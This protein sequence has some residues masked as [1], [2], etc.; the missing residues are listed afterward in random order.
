MSQPK[1]IAPAKYTEEEIRACVA[2]LEDIIK[3][4]SELAHL[5]RE[6]RIAL[7][8]AAGHLSRPQRDE[9]RKR[10]RDSRIIKKEKH[11]NYEHKLR[12]ETGIRSARESV[13]FVAPAQIADQDPG[14]RFRKE[15]LISPRDCYICKQP[16]TRVHFFYDAM[17]PKCAEF[18]YAKRFQTASLAGRVAL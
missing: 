6:L 10:K 9:I 3:N 8:A 13:V 5:P 1:T 4:S 16:F 18:N 7:I 2:L 12:A 14:S 17:C 15:E 11:I